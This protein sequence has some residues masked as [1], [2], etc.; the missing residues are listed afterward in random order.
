MI[1]DVRQGQKVVLVVQAKDLDEKI[2]ARCR[3]LVADR[4]ECEV[5]LAV[6][7]VSKEELRAVLTWPECAEGN[8]LAVVY[9]LDSLSVP[10]ALKTARKVSDEIYTIKLSQEQPV[11]LRRINGEADYDK[12]RAHVFNRVSAKQEKGYVYFP[13]GYL[14]RMAGQGPLDEFGF[15]IS[16]D[17]VKLANRPRNHKLI[18]TFGGSTTWSIDC[19]PSETYTSQLESLLNADIR[20]QGHGLRYTCLNFG[21]VAYSVLS[22][23]IS[24]ILFAWDIRPN[25]V[26]A[27]DGWNDL[28][29]GSYTDPYLVKER[30]IVYPCDLEPWGQL[31]HDG[32]GVQ[33]AKNGPKP[34]PLR[35]AP[36]HILG[37][38]LYRKHQ[39]LRVAEAA[40]CAFVW[41]LQPCI[42]DKRSHS[43]QELSF[44][45]PASP[46]NQDDWRDVRKRVPEL[47]RQV[48]A[49]ARGSV[50]HFVN[51]GEA[52]ADLPSDTQH[53]TDTVHL[54]PA[55]DAEVALVYKNYIVNNLLDSL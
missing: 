46:T 23:M 20:V 11:R 54:T 33:T 29:Y 51:C 3:K 26:L 22:E 16:A 47:L 53:F 15:R 17:L 34:Y 35:S 4:F 37:A 14:Y 9:V 10:L 31:L 7:A 52:F 18:V 12:A 48:E 24:F 25:I 50:P 42:H 36:S 45:D 38:Y 32:G 13:Y 27:H 30:S 21:Q 5:S 43:K 55:G 41:G 8:W 19:L 44:L 39:F 49:A 40:G 2:L 1:G 6:P 28:L